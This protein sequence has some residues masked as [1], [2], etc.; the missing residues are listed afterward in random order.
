MLSTFIILIANTCYDEI[1]LNNNVKII[2]VN[3]L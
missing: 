3:E 2:K 1:K